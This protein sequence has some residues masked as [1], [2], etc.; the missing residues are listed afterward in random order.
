MICDKCGGRGTI[1][2]KQHFGYSRRTYTWQ[3]PCDDCGG[4]GITHCC[5][6]LRE[7]PEKQDDDPQP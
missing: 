2:F 5:D 3:K 6:G 1:H 4:T 7:Q